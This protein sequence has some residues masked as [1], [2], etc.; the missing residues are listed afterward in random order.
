ML[1]LILDFLVLLCVQE[2]ARLKEEH[3]LNDTA[4]PTV[5]GGGGDSSSIPSESQ[6]THCL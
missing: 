1:L 5:G 6:Y 2:M 3:L 4:L